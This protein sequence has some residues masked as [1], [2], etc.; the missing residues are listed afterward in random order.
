MPYPK[1]P[2]GV[3][4]WVRV[5]ERKKTMLQRIMLLT[6]DPIEII[7]NP[8]SHIVAN[9]KGFNLP[10]IALLLRAA[11]IFA[12]LISI[13]WCLIKLLYEHSPQQ[14]AEEKAEITHKFYILLLIGSFVWMFNLAFKIMQGFFGTWG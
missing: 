11:G 6:Y 10:E 9:Y 12:C 7:Y 14:V 4:D 5:L 13:T 8:G 2:L 3:W 1:P